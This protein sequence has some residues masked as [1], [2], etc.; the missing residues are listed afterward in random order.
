[1]AEAASV[2]LAAG[3]VL[4]GWAMYHWVYGHRR[5]VRVGMTAGFAGLVL[6]SFVMASTHGAGLM[7]APALLPLCSEAAA[8]RASWLI[9]LFATG[10]HTLTAVAATGLIG[11]GVYYWVG[12]GI[13][14]RG[15]IN[16]D[17]LWT[18]ALGSAGLLLILSAA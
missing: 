18:G 5:R 6:W 11:L 4:A 1:V 14:R 9:G 8:A 2:R 3:G 16:F 17:L 15:W 13:L 12:L 10:L 7:L